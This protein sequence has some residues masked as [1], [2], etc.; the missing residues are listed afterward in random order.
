MFIR[1]LKTAMCLYFCV[2]WIHVATIVFFGRGKIDKVGKLLEVIEFNFFLSKRK[3]TRLL[4][5][6]VRIGF[7]G[8]NNMKD[9]FQKSIRAWKSVA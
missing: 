7:H 5:Y 1:P 6:R 3:R 4:L 2:L 9:V 8:S